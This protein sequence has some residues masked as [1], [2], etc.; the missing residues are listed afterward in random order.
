MKAYKPVSSKLVVESAIES[1]NKSL[2]EAAEAEKKNQKSYT[3][4]EEFMN[5]RTSRLA[6]NNRFTSFSQSLT[7]SLLGECVYHV[8]AKAMD[9]SVMQQPGTTAMMRAMVGDFL[10]EDASVVYASM[11][12][13][14]NMLAE[15]YDLI[16]KTKK[17]ILEAD[18]FDRM[19][20]STYRIDTLTKDNF[21]EE[22]E[23]LNTD[24]V[25]DAIRE[26]V[27]AALDEFIE[28]NHK[29]HEKIVGALELTAD[30]LKEVEDEPDAVKESYEHLSKQ[31]IAKVRNRKKSVFESMVMAVCE[32][33][34]KDEKLK[35]EFMEDN[36]LNIDKI[37]SR[38]QTMYTFMET[39]NTM[40]LYTIDEAYI[41]EL[42]QNLRV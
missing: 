42:L 17:A 2:T 14:S 36:K 24:S 30:K 7:N 35:K 3:E 6:Q 28:N 13:K 16:G 15:M 32:S 4:A 5:I 40:N 23:G 31:F 26:K 37:V 39:V 1:Y 27:T 8:F 38:V 10:N 21:F 11:R 33:T 25:S 9:E 41:E 18:G 29:D 22:L 20:P 34:L 19:D 12:K